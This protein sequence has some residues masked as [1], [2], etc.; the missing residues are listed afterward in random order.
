MRGDA[1]AG[2]GANIGRTREFATSDGAGGVRVA[3][4]LVSEAREMLDTLQDLVARQSEKLS[5]AERLLE[6]LDYA[7][8][9]RGEQVR[10]SHAKKT[11]GS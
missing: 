10:I 5:A 7:Q 3:A 8:T 2:I 4:E 6:E 1:D 11:D 9:E